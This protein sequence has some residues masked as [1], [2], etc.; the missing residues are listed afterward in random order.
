MSVQRSIK[1]TIY[2]TPRRNKGWWGTGISVFSLSRKWT[3]G[4]A[5]VACFQATGPILKVLHTSRQW[6]Y[7]KHTLMDTGLKPH[8]A[9]LP[10]VLLSDDTPVNNSPD[11]HA[12]RWRQWTE[13]RDT[14]A[15]HKTG[16][17]PAVFQAPKFI[18][19][20]CVPVF[21][22]AQPLIS[23]RELYG[24]LVTPRRFLSCNSL[25]AREWP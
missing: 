10:G 12:R 25:F 5:E 15:S 23:S 21:H 19:V 7:S 4:Q 20:Y 22:A 8:S 18:S 13:N 14:A 3:A 17:P 6:H 11:A 1:Q 16:P 24:R 2:T 9:R